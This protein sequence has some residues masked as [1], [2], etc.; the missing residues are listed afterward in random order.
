MRSFH[1]VCVFAVV[2][3]VMALAFT[4]NSFARSLTL[5]KGD[6]VE[7]QSA[8]G[9][10]KT[11]PKPLEFVFF[12]KKGNTRIPLGVKSNLRDET[13][14]SLQDSASI[15][16]A[17]IDGLPNGS[18]YSVKDVSAAGIKTEAQMVMSKWP[19][20]A[21]KYVNRLKAVQKEKLNIHCSPPTSE[22]TPPAAKP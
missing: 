6:T 20:G 17:H 1:L 8:L 3:S 12:G 13:F 14:E 15:L 21:Q 7:I 9:S 16:Q 2:L 4:Q 11:S 10:E 19:V 18:T 5:T 22:A